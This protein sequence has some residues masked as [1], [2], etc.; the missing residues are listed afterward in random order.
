MKIAILATD[1]DL[2]SN[3]RLMEAGVERGHDMRFVAIRNCY[4]D[5]TA[6]K[7]EIRYRGGEVLEKFDAIIPRIRPAL[8]FYG[9]AVLRPI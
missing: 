4:M 8:T 9:T 6:R 7:P 1:P 5:I 2:Y 3:K